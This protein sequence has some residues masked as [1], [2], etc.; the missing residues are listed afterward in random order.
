[1]PFQTNGDQQMTKLPTQNKRKYELSAAGRFQTVAGVGFLCL[2]WMQYL[3]PSTPSGRWG[4]LET[5]LT[6][7]IGKNGFLAALV[8][9]GIVL[10]L[11]AVFEMIKT[12]KE[13]AK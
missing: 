3:S 2:A 10:M 6:R 12:S 11:S 1:M 7:H 13:R 8:V 4:W 9:V 5:L